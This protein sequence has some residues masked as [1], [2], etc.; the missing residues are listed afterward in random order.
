MCWLLELWVFYVVVKKFCFKNLFYLRPE[1]LPSHVG[2]CT[3]VN[4]FFQKLKKN[5]KVKRERESERE[6]G[7]ERHIKEGTKQK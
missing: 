3:K 4:C 5:L 7:R 1:K 6:R 2:T